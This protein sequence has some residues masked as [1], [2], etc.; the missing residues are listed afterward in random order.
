MFI[1]KQ[2]SNSHICSRK[3]EF[4]IRSKLGPALL[5][6]SREAC[7]QMFLPIRKYIHKLKGAA[8]PKSVMCDDSCS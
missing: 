7:R 1:G 6:L 2:E 4:V 8:L 5:K 3:A